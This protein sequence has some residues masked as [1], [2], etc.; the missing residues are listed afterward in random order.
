MYTTKN[1]SEVVMDYT[2]DLDRRLGF[3]KSCIQNTQKRK[4]RI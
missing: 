1:N 2:M 3:G 4:S